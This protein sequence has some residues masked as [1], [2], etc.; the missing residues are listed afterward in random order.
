[1]GAPK[2]WPWVTPGAAYFST[3]SHM[4]QEGPLLGNRLCLLS[5]WNMIVLSSLNSLFLHIYLCCYPV[6][7][8]LRNA[9]A[10]W[11]HL[12]SSNSTIKPAKMGLIK[13]LLSSCKKKN[14][15]CIPQLVSI[16]KLMKWVTNRQK[17]LFK[18]KLTASGI[19][20]IKIAAWKI[21]S[22][23]F[24]KIV[25]CLSVGVLG[26]LEWPLDRSRQ[27]GILPRTF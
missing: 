27:Y 26:I 13:N 8:W 25:L 7:T 10:K 2:R 16:S 5:P 24:G 19:C 6:N 15:P 14:S 4:Q 18:S 9:A 11:I 12:S 3:E 22:Q 20:I 21:N 1:M 23:G 17:Y